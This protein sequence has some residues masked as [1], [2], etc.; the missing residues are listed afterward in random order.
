MNVLIPGGGGYIGSML[1]PQLL[2][3]GHL[4][5]VYDTMWFGDCASDDEN[6]SVIR[7]DIRSVRDMNIACE[8]QDAVICLAAIS[9]ETMCQKY[10]T[11][12][13]TVNMGGAMGVAIAAARAGV[14]RFIYASSVAAY[15][16][17]GKASAETDEMSPTTI[18]GACKVEAEARVLKS[19][20]EAVIVRSASVCGYSEHM[21][22]DLT[23][24]KMV[25]DAIRRG[26][27]TVNG[28]NQKRSHI[29]MQDICD[30][31]SLLLDL[32][33]EISAGQ[34]FNVVAENQTVLETAE[35]VIRTLAP[36]VRRSRNMPAFI[37]VQDATDER[38]YSVDGTKARDVLGF[39]PR[40]KVQDAV[41]DLK[42]KFDDGLWEDSMTN[43]LYQNV[44]EFQS[45]PP[46]CL[47][48]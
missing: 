14:K 27:I 10:P 2:S 32:A 19:F 48:A 37:K 36:H 13:R 26:V 34:A 41:Q 3:R 29:H 5:K 47:T 21:R 4:V 25:H 33:P 9:A 46:L 6:L 16:S 20:P 45:L 24:N 42:A 17:S 12:A 8:G 15:A 44:V 38:S 39:V 35:I 28:G 22:F 43:G 31:Y 7:E 40:K 23:V 30:F 11:L 1:V 18:Y